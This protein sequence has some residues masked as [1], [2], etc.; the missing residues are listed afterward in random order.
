M[1]PSRRPLAALL[2]TLALA[3]VP[4][5]AHAAD[6]QMTIAAHVTLA[7]RWLDPG[8]TESAITPFLVLYAVH[9]ALAKPM[10]AGPITPSLAESWSVSP[11]GTTYEFLLRAAKFHNGDPVTAEDV[12][13]SFERYKGGAAAL[14]KSKVKEIRVLDARRVSVVLKEAWPDFMTF[15]GTTATG[16]GWIVPKKHI[17]RV[18]EEAFRRAPIGAGPY[19]FV[20]SSPGIELVLEAFDG[21][22]RKAPSVKRVVIKSVPDETTRAAALKRNEVDVGYFFNGPVAEDIRRTPGLRLAAART[23]AVFFLDFV[24]QW[25][26]KSPWADRRVRLAASVALDRKAINEA[27][28]LGFAGLTANIVPRSMEFAL[29][30]EPHPFD[31]RRAK[32]LLTEAGYPNG[33]D[34]GDL[35]PN[36]PYFS[37]AEA[38]AGNLAAVGIRTRIR[39]MERAAWLT[40][41]REKKL[42]GVVLAAQGAGGNAATRIESMA[43]RGGMYAYGVLP[44]VEDLFQR[45]ARELDRKKREELLH[46]IQRILNDQVVFAPIWEN[47]FIRGVGPRVEEAALTLVPSYP[48]TAP[49]EELRLKEKR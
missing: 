9:D 2:L 34:G 21:Y 38:V 36:P 41:W 47:A 27:E 43:T 28:F 35:T 26:P 49:F 20:S 6:G 11:D 45:Q 24:E 8:E 12:K 37:M 4:R 1:R 5:A 14:L 44:E 42:R 17:E 40:A 3:T 22:W 13:F 7:P 25:D 48:Y 18:G 46:Q 19:K 30:L 23:Y 31:P 33:F 29:P 16:A 10:P 32:Q 39:T 15:Y